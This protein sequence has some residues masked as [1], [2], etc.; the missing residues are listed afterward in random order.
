MKEVLPQ[1]CGGCAA[2][3]QALLLRSQ[4]REPKKPNGVA[5]M[6]EGEEGGGESTEATERAE[7]RQRVRHV[8]EKHL[9]GLKEALLEQTGGAVERLQKA[10]AP[11]SAFRRNR[12][13][14]SVSVFEDKSTGMPTDEGPS[15]RR[16]FRRSASLGHPS[17]RLTPALLALEDVDTPCTSTVVS[18]AASEVASDTS[19]SPS[20]RSSLRDVQDCGRGNRKAS[21]IT[22]EGLEQLQAVDQLI[23]DSD[24]DKEVSAP[25]PGARQ[26]VGSDASSVGRKSDASSVNWRADLLDVGEHY[27]AAS[28]AKKGNTSINDIVSLV[29]AERERWEE[30][31]QALEVRIEELKEQL[32]T[33]QARH[34]PD[35]EKQALKAQ[36]QDLR[37]AQKARSRFGAWVCARHMMESD[38]EET[39]VE[40]EDLRRKMSDLTTR[41][42][43]AK[44]AL[45][46][47]S[48]ESDVS[49]RKCMSPGIIRRR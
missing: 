32:R 36:F 49:P 46:A 2:G 13:K 26:R 5:W 8:A 3:L 47:A 37:K 43:R 35:A 11:I 17:D 41:L 10:R 39:N 18:A 15:I 40:K 33:L 29:E 1:L 34:S 4:C 7:L 20:R 45:G 25:H 22:F 9:V 14:R 48:S 21:R 19:D 16:S 23:S 27:A 6:V 28:A 38:D 42:R 30:E 12:F 24:D 31:K 44:A